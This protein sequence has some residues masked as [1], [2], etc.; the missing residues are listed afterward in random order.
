MKK[1]TVHQLKSVFKSVFGR[2]PKRAQ[3]DINQ[4]VVEGNELRFLKKEY[5]RFK[6]KGTNKINEFREYLESKIKTK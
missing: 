1:I 3:Y 6:S 4:L 5:N 2:K